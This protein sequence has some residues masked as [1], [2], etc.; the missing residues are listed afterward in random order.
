M[1]SGDANFE[2]LIGRVLRL[3]VTAASVCLAIGLGLTFAGAAPAAGAWLLSAGLII[4]IMTPAARVIL[5]IVEYIGARDWKFATLT[6]IVLIELLAGAVAAL[7][8]HRGL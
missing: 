8:F 6:A 1:T 3:G 2:L 7:V 5:S 4:L